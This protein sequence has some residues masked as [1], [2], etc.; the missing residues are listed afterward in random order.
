MIV[1]AGFDTAID[2]PGGATTVRSANG[3]AGPQ[4]EPLAAGQVS[5][6]F[7]HHVPLLSRRHSPAPVSRTRVPQRLRCFFETDRGMS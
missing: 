3:E 4:A 7:R 2:D 6:L 1:L 5:S